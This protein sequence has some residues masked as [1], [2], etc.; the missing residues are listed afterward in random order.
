ML[1]HSSLLILALHGGAPKDSALDVLVDFQP[2]T[3]ATVISD[4]LKTSPGKKVD[5]C[6]SLDA[7]EPAIA[8]A[9]N[10]RRMNLPE[11]SINHT[12]HNPLINQPIVVSIET[13]KANP[14]NPVNAILQCGIWHMAQ[15][16]ILRQ[17]VSP[18]RYFFLK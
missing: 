7:Q 10:D 5:F 15:W 9:I 6:I 4:Y 3:L 2:C 18:Y 1:V 12:A 11:K 13:K 8:K 14:D 16:R 17:L